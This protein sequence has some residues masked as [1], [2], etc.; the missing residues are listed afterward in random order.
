MYKVIIIDDE[1]AAIEALRRDL[2]MQANLEI[3]GTA[4]NGNWART[5]NL[6]V[7]EIVND[8]FVRQ[9][10]QHQAFLRPWEADIVEVLQFTVVAGF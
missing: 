9:T 8:V 5:D 2:E 10:D 4:G 1:K 6:A 7:V 3:K